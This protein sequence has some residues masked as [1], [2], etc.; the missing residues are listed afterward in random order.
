MKTKGFLS[1]VCAANSSVLTQTSKRRRK[2]G[3]RKSA[4]GGSIG[5]LLTC[6]ILPSGVQAASVTWTTSTSSLLDGGG[7]WMP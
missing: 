1:A 7:T 3:S 6:A 2:A 5:A 4:L